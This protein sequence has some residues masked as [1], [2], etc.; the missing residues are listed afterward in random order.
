M[1]STSLPELEASPPLAFTG[2]ASDPPASSTAPSNFDVDVGAATDTSSPPT[3]SSRLAPLVGAESARPDAPCPD[4]VVASALS[5]RSS[6]SAPVTVVGS[7]SVDRTSSASLATTVDDCPPKSLSPSSSRGAI[8]TGDEH[9]VSSQVDAS[10]AHEPRLAPNPSLSDAAA[11]SH[12]VS[13]SS[14]LTSPVLREVVIADTLD[15]K[16]SMFIASPASTEN[17]TTLVSANT[18]TKKNRRVPML[19]TGISGYRVAP[20]NVSAGASSTSTDS[21]S[22]IDGLAISFVHASPEEVAAELFSVASPCFV[23]GS[24]QAAAKKARSAKPPLNMDR[25]DEAGMLERASTNVGVRDVFCPLVLSQPDAN[26]MVV[27]LYKKKSSSSSTV[28]EL[29][30]NVRRERKESVPSCEV[31]LLAFDPADEAK[32]RESS[33]SAASKL[34][35]IRE[36]LIGSG[37]QVLNGRET[38]HLSMVSVF[39][40]SL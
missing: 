26:R 32:L 5:P 35:D 39:L 17:R 12:A 10:A 13:L 38:G 21:Q 29:M 30:Y 33:L 14:C 20:S 37:L 3:I 31:I 23:L 25:I 22:T 6:P 2:S 1:L 4:D 18:L 36:R 34:D 7:S 11:S 24:A 19:F 28:I 8:S 40:P 15:F 27:L 16:A 9:A